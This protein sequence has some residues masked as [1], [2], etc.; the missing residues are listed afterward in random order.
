MARGGASFT[1][2]Q[3]RLLSL[4]IADDGYAPPRSIEALG[5]MY[6]AATVRVREVAP[7]EVG[8]KAIGHFGFFRRRFEPSLWTMATDHLGLGAAP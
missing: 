3:G 8:A 5:Q 2:W 4:A 7:R 1:R 6:R